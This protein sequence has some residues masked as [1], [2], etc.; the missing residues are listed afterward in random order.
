MRSRRFRIVRSVRGGWESWSVAACSMRT[1]RFDED[2]EMFLWLKN[3]R[4]A[5]GAKGT[6]RPTTPV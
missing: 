6:T 2:I 3:R 4:V 5:T 1:A